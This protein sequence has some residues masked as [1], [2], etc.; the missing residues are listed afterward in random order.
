MKCETHDH[1]LVSHKTILHCPICT[2]IHQK[3]EEKRIVKTTIYLALLIG[4]V[5]LMSYF[6]S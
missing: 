6:L 5:T 4:V 3:H 1:P 2:E